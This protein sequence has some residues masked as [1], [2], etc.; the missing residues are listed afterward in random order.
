MSSTSSKRLRAVLADRMPFQAVR[1]IVS[2]VHLFPGILTAVAGGVF[3]LLV[4]GE[5]RGFGSVLLFGSM[6]LISAAVGSMN[7]YLDLD[8]DRR[9]QPNKPLVRGDIPP[10]TA[11]VVSFA[12]SAGGALLSSCFGWQA[13]AMSLVV[14]AS[15]MAYN[16]WA[17]GTIWSWA[18]YA[19]AIPALPIWAFVAADKF[20]PVVLL[21]FPLGALTSLAVNL[22]NTLP[23]LAGDARYGLK[24]LAHR[25]GLQR[26]IIVIWVSFGG[27]IGLLALTPIFIDSKPRALFPGLILG[28][29]LLL[30]MIVDYA[31]SRSAASLRRGWYFSSILTALLGGTWIASLSSG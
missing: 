22:A 2:V 27:V 6:F 4:I 15:G 26:S 12:A 29:V 18:P 7:D 24:G 17:K 25:L 11:V 31:V 23:D 28:S 8:L 20:R 3:Y 14:L 21:T 19:I 9:A 30:V 13:L 5:V 10:E 1:G 16:F